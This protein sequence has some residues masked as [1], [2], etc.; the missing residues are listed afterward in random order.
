MS[1][2]AENL[3]GQVLPMSSIAA[4]I[5]MDYELH[6]ALEKV[7]KIDF[8]MLKVKVCR[9]ENLTMEECEEIEDLYRKFLALNMR[10]PDRKI[11][12]TGPIDIFWHAHILD[13]R[14]YAKDCEI[15]F[16]HMLH[17]FPYFGMRGAQDKQDLDKT[18]ARSVELF[19][20]HYGIDPTRG[21]TEARS[22]SVQN[23]P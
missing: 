14:A 18:F 16:G 10:Y 19:I 21:D 22:C 15:L 7:A 13:T 6:A 9:D 23:C 12:P 11:C 2:T 1:Q 3:S 17:H 4:L 5:S 20:R 8:S